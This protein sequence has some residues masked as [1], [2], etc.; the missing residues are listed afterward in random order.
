MLTAW[1]FHV[2]SLTGNVDVTLR[3]KAGHAAHA[4]EIAIYC[5]SHEMIMRARD[6]EHLLRKGTRFRGA[7]CM[8][9]C[10]GRCIRCVPTA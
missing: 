10:E 9:S 2:Y 7:I 8:Q 6:L 5:A 1:R 3:M 4:F